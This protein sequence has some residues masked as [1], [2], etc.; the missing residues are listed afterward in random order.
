MKPIHTMLYACLD[1]RKVFK[2][3]RY[4]LGEGRTWETIDYERICPQC[5]QHLYETGVAFKAPKQTDLKQWS[6]IAALLRT[7]YRF[8]PNFGSPIEKPAPQKKAP[9]AKVP[10][11]EFRKPSRKRNKNAQQDAPSNGG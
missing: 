10:N 6:K 1:C 2:K 9:P 11:S 3:P 4:E 5:S 7:G 8:N